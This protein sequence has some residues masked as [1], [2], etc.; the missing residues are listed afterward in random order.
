M[1][2][3]YPPEARPRPSSGGEATESSAP[4]ESRK[5][6]QKETDA[7][8]LWRSLLDEGGANIKTTDHVDA[9]RYAKVSTE[10]DEFCFG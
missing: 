2:G 5:T 6:T 10:L 9:V 3:L 7:L 1:S 8:E 4:L